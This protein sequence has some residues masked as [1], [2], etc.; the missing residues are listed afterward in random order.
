MDIR[1]IRKIYLLV[2][3]SRSFHLKLIQAAHSISNRQARLGLLHYGMLSI[4]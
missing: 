3:I 4:I 2:D 1:R